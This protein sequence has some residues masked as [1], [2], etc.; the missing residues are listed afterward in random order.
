VRSFVAL[1]R[2]MRPYRRWA[3]LAPLFMVLEVAMDLVQ[4][5]LMQRVVDVG[6]AN[7]DLTLIGHC[8]VY[9]VGAAVL[10]LFFGSACSVFAVLAGLSFGADIRASLMGRVQDMAYADLDHHHTGRLITRLTNDVDQVQEAAMMIMRIL[11][12]APLTVVGAL[13]M[14][15]IT[16]PSL[17]PLIVVMCPLFV[18]VFVVI[19]KRGHVLFLA[20]QARLDR[21]NEVLQENLA[22]ARLVRAF[23][24]APHEER[25][26]GTANDDLM[27]RGIAAGM[28][29]ASALPLLILT[30]Q[31]GTV[32]A[33]WLAGRQI[34]AG[35]A[36][37]GQL[38]AFNQYLMQMTFNL[39]MVGMFIVRLVQ[40]DASAE[41]IKEVLETA[42]SLCDAPEA[43]VPP[44][45]D[46]AV[47]WHD[48][49]FRYRGERAEPVLRGIDIDVAPGETLAI[50]G[51]TGSGKS[52]LAHLVSRFYDV[53]AGA[54][55]VDGLAVGAMTQAALRKRIAVVPQTPNLFSGT[56]ADN[57]RF[58]ARDAG[59][60]EVREAARLA[61][62]E[63]FIEAMADGYQ[64]E[65]EARG[66]NLS[67]G[68]RQRLAIARALVCR[69]E[70]LILDDCTSA[71]DAGTEAR[72]L[73]ALRTWQHRCTRLIIAQRL[74]AIRAADRVVVLEDGEVV[75]LGTHDELLASCATYADMVR[76]QL[77]A[78]GDADA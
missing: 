44:P 73:A 34:I 3:L 64:S 19:T 38:M 52:S 20:V 14:A 51:A 66:T 59:D 65:L 41:R 7:H 55:R 21:V 45:G 25:R 1:L 40:A 31:L 27:G 68:Q 9:M 16:Y 60:E 2:F 24:R 67:G 30:I 75:G 13:I 18:A 15:V 48:V 72:L 53:E 78:P 77:D 61:Q 58:G 46:G 33:V 29:T 17:S 62:A 50:V 35:H 49:T 74:G 63:S 39:M 4:P 22:G 57:I 37:V 11:V 12:R 76:S 47:S 69:P 32:A 28:L 26:F 54:V 10:G 6:M 42:P 5:R 23:V 71:L 70:V 8:A 43:V 56:I 36:Q